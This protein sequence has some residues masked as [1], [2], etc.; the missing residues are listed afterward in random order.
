MPDAFDEAMNRAKSAAGRA[1]G[2]AE[3]VAESRT[4]ETIARV[5]YVANGLM[6][7]LI[8]YLGVRLA[9][10]QAG[11]ADQ[12]GA[13]AQLAGSPGGAVLLWTGVIGCGALALWQLGE[14]FFGF[15]RLEKRKKW[16]KRLK[17]GALAVIYTA[18]GL[19]FLAFARG[20]GSSSGQTSQDASTRLMSS[21]G[22]TI[23]LFLIG[24]AI[25]V[26]GGYFLY[27]GAKHKFLEDL[28]GLPAGTAGTVMTW[29][30]TIG[31]VGKGVALAVL[32]VLLC[33][34]AARHDPSKATGLDGALKGLKELPLGTA[35]LIFVAIGF[36][37]YGIYTMARS[38][39]AKM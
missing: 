32:G 17:A 15:R 8:G 18:L 39:Y 16:G 11:E 37:C 35:L 34:A 3:G 12:S 10:G 13:I 26:V 21:P 31:Y 7:L 38:R 22:G 27:K 2:A 4:L 33:I 24:A 25:I 1:A 28:H 9:M 29:A 36:A 19:T 20:G 14:A 30:G 23:V 5:G 6:H